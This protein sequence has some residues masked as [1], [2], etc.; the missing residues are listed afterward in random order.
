MA[1]E[2]PIPLVTIAD[3][4]LVPRLKAGESDAFEILVRVHGPRMLAVARRYLPQEADA[5]DALQD[6]FMDVLRGI[7]TFQGQSK[8]STWLHRVTANASLMRL[9]SR[10]RRPEEPIAPPTIQSIA[11][12]KQSDERWM[13]D[14]SHIL[15][16]RD[17]R[18]QVRACI[19]R[20]PEAY[21]IVLQLRDIQG[22]EM[23]EVGRLLGLTRST[24]RIRLHRGRHALRDL[25]KDALQGEENT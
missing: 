8:L 17:L 7:H 1:Q 16:R 6:A 15:S 4:E 19:D 10:M 24:V 23:D 18:E 13:H 20:L 2:G 14:T 25:L 22:I 11:D 5:Q 9:R 3:A 12:R 21:R